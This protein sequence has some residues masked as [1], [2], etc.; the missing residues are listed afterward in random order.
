[1]DDVAETIAALEK[2]GPIQT[3]EDVPISLCLYPWVRAGDG[4]AVISY[5]GQRRHGHRWGMSGAWDGRSCH[6]M[7]PASALIAKPPAPGLRVTAAPVFDVILSAEKSVPALLKRSAGVAADYSVSSSPPSP[8]EAIDIFTSAM[9]RIDDPHPTYQDRFKSMLARVL[10]GGLPVSFFTVRAGWACVGFKVIWLGC[11]EPISVFT[12]TAAG[13]TS[14]SRLMW[15]A[16]LEA[17]GSINAGDAYRLPGL[18]RFKMEMKPAELRPYFNVLL[19][20]EIADY[21]QA[22]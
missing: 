21:E 9:D 6:Y 13:H 19:H 20:D 12:F 18:L 22:V 2:M 7:L 5:P 16:A 4:C 15:A 3:F 11:S 17:H 10:S 8:D 14:A 1:V